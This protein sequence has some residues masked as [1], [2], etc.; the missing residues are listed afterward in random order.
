M[1]K[2]L[3]ELTAEGRYAPAIMMGGEVLRQL[4]ERLTAGQKTSFQKLIDDAKVR[5]LAADRK[6]VQQLSAQLQAPD[7]T[8]RGAAAAELKAMGDRAVGPLVGAL[9]SVVMSTPPS[10]DVEK[11][12]VAILVQIA[13]KLTGYNLAETK[14]LR[15]KKIDGWA[16]SL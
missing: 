1:E 14:E 10:P 16:K 4:S 7:A 11:S 2:R 3:G 5:Q 15:L 9:R 8:T 6:R 13:P 12:I